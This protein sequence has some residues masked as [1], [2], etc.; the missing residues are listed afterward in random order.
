MAYHGIYVVQLQ[1]Q[2]QASQPASQLKVAASA[3]LQNDRDV[4]VLLLVGNL[5]FF[6]GA[7]VDPL[8]WS[9]LLSYIPFIIIHSQFGFLPCFWCCLFAISSR[10]FIQQLFIFEAWVI[11]ALSS[12]SPF[13]CLSTVDLIASAALLLQR[14]K[15]ACLQGSF[16]FARWVFWVL[17]TWEANGLIVSV[18][19]G[20]QIK[21]G[22]FF[23]L[24]AWSP[25]GL[26]TV[27]IYLVLWSFALFS[28]ADF[29]S[30]VD[31]LR[32]ILS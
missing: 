21:A 29:G 17:G 9:Y 24:Q 13:L 31:R 27:W 32:A 18:L 12:R 19:L 14:R 30:V 15:S 25:E 22:N 28:T 8:I 4:K 2:Q 3:S 5:F 1:Q 7:S 26:T 6:R 16:L 20:Q 10:F 11:L 23:S